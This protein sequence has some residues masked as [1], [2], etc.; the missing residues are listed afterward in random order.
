MRVWTVHVRADGRDPVRLVREGFAWGACLLGPFWLLGRRLWLGA[1][2]WVAVAVLLAF[3]PG[4][5]AFPL[6]L[7]L[8]LLT[9]A[10]G[11][12][13]LRHTL[14]RQ[15]FAALGVVAA[16]DEDAAL[17]RLLAQRPD[18]AAPLA[19]AVLA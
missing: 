6:M 4:K 10:H 9:G 1:L 7:G 17:A 12:D 3:L 5:A 8:C 18:L 16:P 19:R 2:S 11:R 13:L 14:A 15:G